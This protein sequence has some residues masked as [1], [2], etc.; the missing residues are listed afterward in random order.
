MPRSRSNSRTRVKF[1]KNKMSLRAK[2][3]ARVKTTTV[4]TSQK[5]VGGKKSSKTSYVTNDIQQIVRP[6]RKP[7]LKGFKQIMNRDPM[8]MWSALTHALGVDA[9][10]ALKFMISPGDEAVKC[11]FPDGKS[12]VSLT[13]PL[14]QSFEISPPLGTTDP[15]GALIIMYPSLDFPLHVFTTT[16]P[17]WI[18]DTASVEIGTAGLTNFKVYNWQNFPPVLNGPDID[19]LTPGLFGPADVVSTPFSM[20]FTDQLVLTDVNRIY[21][22]TTAAEDEIASWRC[23]GASLTTK[24]DATGLTNSGIVYSSQLFREMNEKLLWSQTTV[25]S[26]SAPAGPTTSHNNIVCY[27]PSIPIIDIPN[28]PNLITVQNHYAGNS[29]DGSYNVMRYLGESEFMEVISSRKV[30]TYDNYLQVGANGVLKR[31]YQTRATKTPAGNYPN[32]D[33]SLSGTSGNA[34]V[35]QTLDKSFTPVIQMFVNLNPGAKLALKLKMSTEVLVTNDGRLSTLMTKTPTTISTFEDLAMALSA[36]LK[37]GGPFT[38][39]DFLQTLKDIGAGIWD[40]VKTVAPVILP[41]LL[42]S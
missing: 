17:Q 22:M 38:D 16:N 23:C 7:K 25:A 33:G 37:V 1:S 3:P 36:R 42:K 31:T 30:I 2:S 39:N 20:V 41:L 24:L 6:P 18:F 4:T 15:W 11:G 28:T 34:Q 14:Q 8:Q 21:G 13:Y 19:G 40:V 27:W 26:A 32:P 29:E 35:M 12:A 5:P 9:V 10:Q